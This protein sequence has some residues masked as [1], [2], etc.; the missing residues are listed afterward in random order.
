V[1]AGNGRACAAET[2]YLLNN[3][4]FHTFFEESGIL[5]FGI[6]IWIQLLSELLDPDPHEMN[7]NPQPCICPGT[8]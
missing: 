4:I 7:A 8:H 5:N 2:H 3:Q 1:R 6:Q